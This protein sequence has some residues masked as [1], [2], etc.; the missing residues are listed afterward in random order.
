M[1]PVTAGSNLVIGH[2]LHTILVALPVE[3][4]VSD[5]HRRCP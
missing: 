3:V 1:P 5:D 4:P 2:H